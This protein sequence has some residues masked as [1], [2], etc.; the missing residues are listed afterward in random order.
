MKRVVLAFGLFFIVP[1]LMGDVAAPGGGC[2][3]D[4]G[5][6]AERGGGEGE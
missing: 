6:G 3:C 2:G 1:A 4:G 5:G